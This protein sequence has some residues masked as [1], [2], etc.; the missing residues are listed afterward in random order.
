MKAGLAD[1]WSA[2]TGSE[3]LNHWMLAK[4][5]EGYY[6]AKQEDDQRRNFVQHVVARRTDFL[7][8]IIATV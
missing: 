1:H 5:K 3:E 4:L 7:R 8:R 6:Q 2:L